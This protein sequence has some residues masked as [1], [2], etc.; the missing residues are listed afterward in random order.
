MDTSSTKEIDATAEILIGLD[1][2]LRRHHYHSPDEDAEPLD[3]IDIGALTNLEWDEKDG[4]WV[5][6][7]D[8]ITF[9][10]TP[11][12]SSICIY[13]DEEP[14]ATL[15]AAPTPDGRHW[16]AD[17]EADLTTSERQHFLRRVGVLGKECTER[18]VAAV[19]RLRAESAGTE[20]RGFVA[21]SVR[22]WL[23]AR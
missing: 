9:D 15:W 21:S 20:D 13:L 22:E 6:L 7:D 2:Q 10:I 17:W 1:L 11:T 4:L 16:T 19:D 14:V 3:L 8:L 12:G 18:V 23:A 5:Q